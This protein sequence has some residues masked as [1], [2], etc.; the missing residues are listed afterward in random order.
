MVVKNQIH[1]IVSGLVQGV[2]FR[3]F[4]R[5]HA[6]KLG[7]KGRVRNLP[8]R[9]V[10]IIAEGEKDKLN[11]FIEKVKEGPSASAVKDCEIEWKEF[12]G[13]YTDFEIIYFD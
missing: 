3:D 5:Q 8:N 1:V 4:T 2:F 6:I 12:S 9:N 10:E 11:Q 7:I 13:E